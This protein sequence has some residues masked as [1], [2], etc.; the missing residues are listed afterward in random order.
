MSDIVWKH[1]NPIR[2]ADDIVLDKLEDCPLLNRNHMAVVEVFERALDYPEH[3]V[4]RVFV[5]GA[6]TAFVAVA[7]TLGDVRGA[8]PLWMYPLKPC[9]EDDTRLVETWI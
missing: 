2:E 5:D 4:A 3:Y 8:I 1:Y 6:A 7:D 9:A